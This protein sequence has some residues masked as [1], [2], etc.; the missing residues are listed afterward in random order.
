MPFTSREPVVQ[1][2]SA[3]VTSNPVSVNKKLLYR[4]NEKTEEN[5]TKSIFT[6]SDNPR[7]LIFSKTFTVNKDNHF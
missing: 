1:V 3:N 7:P 5:E 2:S 6:G 4:D